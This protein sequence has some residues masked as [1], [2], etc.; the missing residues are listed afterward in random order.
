[1]ERD[2][3]IQI[4]RKN[5]VDEREIQVQRNGYIVASMVQAMFILLIMI[6]RYIKGDLFSQD[7]LVIIMA[8]VLTLSLYQFIKLKQP[9]FLLTALIALGA[10]SLTLFNVL[11]EYGYIQ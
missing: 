6:L 1:M 11:I 7:L 9:V 10:L 4:V 8:Q 2:K 3:I 5:K